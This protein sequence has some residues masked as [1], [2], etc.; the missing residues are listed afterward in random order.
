MFRG[1]AA[2]PP[3]SRIGADLAGNDQDMTICV[4]CRRPESRQ[5]RLEPFDLGAGLG[6]ASRCVN[7][8][9]CNANQKPVRW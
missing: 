7:Y 4:A 2:V 9:D 1:Q 6:K 8:R 3:L 5:L